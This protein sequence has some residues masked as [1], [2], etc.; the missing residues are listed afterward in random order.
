MHLS[1]DYTMNRSS[2]RC[3]VEFLSHVCPTFL[4]VVGLLGGPEIPEAC[5]GDVRPVDLVR[6]SNLSVET[7]ES[8]DISVT[9]KRSFYDGGKLA[10]SKT[11]ICQMERLQQYCI[12]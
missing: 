2:Q 1:C 7:D 5:F 6:A 3:N 10:L 9:Q 8:T 4:Q 11:L 12:P